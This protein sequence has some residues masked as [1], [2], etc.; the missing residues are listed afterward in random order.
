[1]AEIKIK[2]GHALSIITG[3]ATILIMIPRL[4]IREL[5]ARISIKLFKLLIR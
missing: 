5:Y 2:Q 4:T 3:V 1:M